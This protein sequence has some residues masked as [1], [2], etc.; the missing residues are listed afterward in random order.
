MNESMNENVLAQPAS[1]KPL[2]SEH[3]YP[4]SAAEVVAAKRTTRVQKPEVHYQLEP[5]QRQTLRSAS[6]ESPTPSS[7]AQPQVSN[8]QCCQQVKI[9]CHK[10]FPLTKTIQTT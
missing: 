7:S 10:Q 8:H 3:A 1:N 2:F 9:K 5:T 6:T 4:V